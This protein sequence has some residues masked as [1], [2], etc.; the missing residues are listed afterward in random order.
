MYKFLFAIFFTAVCAQA[1]E[2]EWKTID[3]SICSNLTN[4]HSMMALQSVLRYAI[5]TNESLELQHANS[6]NFTSAKLLHK[7]FDAYKNKY[8]SN[9]LQRREKHQNIHMAD[10]VEMISDL[11]SPWYEQY[12]QKVG[13]RHLS[14][15]AKKIQFA[16]H[17]LEETL[18][19]IKEKGKCNDNPETFFKLLIDCSQPRF[20]EMPWN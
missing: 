12:C 18:K 20:R 3:P 6:P 8:I 7:A 15:R 14:K 19:M 10:I 4:E 16:L 17:H 1:N 9:Y 2:D 13:T 5:I 11:F